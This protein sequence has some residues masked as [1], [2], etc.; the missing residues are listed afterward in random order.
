MSVVGERAAAIS[1]VGQSQVGRRIYRD[2]LALTVEAVLRA[3]DDAGLTRDD[4]DGVATYPGNMDIPPGFSGAGVTELQ[5]A[6]RLDL[7]WFA[8][9][10]EAPGQLGSVVNAALAVAA[11]PGEPRR[12]LPHRDRG[13]GTGRQGPLVGDARRGRG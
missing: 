7:N 5:D 3:I 12:L 4:I 9:G 6:L 11:G 1:G 13:V 8:G 2:P 10:L